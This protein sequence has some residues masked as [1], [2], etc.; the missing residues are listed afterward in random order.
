[1]CCRK[2]GGG[3]IVALQLDLRIHKG[4]H[5]GDRHGP[6][7]QRGDGEQQ[8]RAEEPEFCLHGVTSSVLAPLSYSLEST[9]NFEY[10]WS[11]SRWPQNR[12]DNSQA[13]AERASGAIDFRLLFESGQGLHLVL[14]PTFEIIAASDAHLARDHDRAEPSHRT[15]RFRSIS[16]TIPT[17]LALRESANYA[18]PWRPCFG[19]AR[20]T[21]WLSRNMTSGGLSPR[22]AD[23]K[24]DTGVPSIPLIM[25]AKW[26]GHLYYSSRRGRDG[27]HPP[28]AGRRKSHS[29]AAHPFRADGSRNLSPG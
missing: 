8:E 28:Q 14:T 20:R 1:M 15:G 7:G 17:I 24:N 5:I 26:R 19:L 12:R 23:L 29:C 25:N 16:R 6:L 3:P 22:A 9:S 27:I 11:D 18:H 4:D 13:E 2:L 10:H 21:P